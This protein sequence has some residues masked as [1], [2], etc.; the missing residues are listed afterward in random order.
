VA[1]HFGT[2]ITEP[3]ADVRVLGVWLDTKPQWRAHAR[4]L[5]RKAVAQVCA[6]MRTAASTWG[7][8]FVR[9]RHIYSAVVRLT[10]SYGASTWHFHSKEGALGPK[11]DAA[12][13]QRI[14]NKCLLTLAGAYRATTIYSLEAE[15]FVPPLDLYLDSRIAAFQRKLEN[16]PIRD[17]STSVR[18]YSRPAQA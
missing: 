5:K 10:L 4:E 16:N 11:G 18:G 9:A 15:T 8:T 6:L 7:A 1:V 2:T 13:G 14:Q 3:V 17:N 12:Q